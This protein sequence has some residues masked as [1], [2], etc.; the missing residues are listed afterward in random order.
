MDLI[1]CKH[2]KRKIE[3]DFACCPFCLGDLKVEKK[4]TKFCPF[5]GQEVKKEY[6]NCP[7]CG[8]SLEKKKQSVPNV[9]A[10]PLTTSPVVESAS[11]VVETPSPVVENISPVAE[12]TSPVAESTVLRCPKCGFEYKS[13]RKFCKN[14]GTNLQ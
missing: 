3:R 12:T 2:C 13:G 5:C 6:H 11:P 10:E 4:D 14:C 7:H 1:S 8:K 9:A